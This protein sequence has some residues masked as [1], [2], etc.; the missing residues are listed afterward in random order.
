MKS[1]SSVP[2]LIRQKHTPEIADEP[3]ERRE[4]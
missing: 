2:E 4:T 1:V 3:Q